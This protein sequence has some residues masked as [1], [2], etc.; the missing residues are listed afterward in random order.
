MKDIT[1]AFTRRLVFAVR[2]FATS[3][4][5][6]KDRATVDAPGCDNIRIPFVCYHKRYPL[7]LIVSSYTMEVHTKG[8]LLFHIGV[9]SALLV[10]VG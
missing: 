8:G 1:K 7:W 6:A 3:G 5:L 4:N 10:S 2:N 9:G